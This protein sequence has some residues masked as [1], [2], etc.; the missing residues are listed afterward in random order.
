[1]ACTLYNNMLGINIIKYRILKVASIVYLL[2]IW[3]DNCWTVQ[4]TWNNLIL[5]SIGHKI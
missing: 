2:I 3:F 4:E 1:M 5:I